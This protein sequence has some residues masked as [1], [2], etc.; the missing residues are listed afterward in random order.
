MSLNSQFI[1]V[2]D[3]IICFSVRLCNNLLLV[4]KMHFQVFPFA[5]K[6]VEGL[7]SDI[8]IVMSFLS[9][10]FHFLKFQFSAK[11]FGETLITSLKSNSFSK[12]L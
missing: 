7:Y 6:K 10:F 1:V 8:K 5:N 2:S 4:L 12:E 3:G 9:V 11:I